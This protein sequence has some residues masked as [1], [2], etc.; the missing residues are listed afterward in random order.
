MMFAWCACAN[1]RSAVYAADCLGLAVRSTQLKKVCVIQTSGQ[2]LLD[3]V[4]AIFGFADEW[5]LGGFVGGGG[6]GGRF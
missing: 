2:R 3:K 5:L 4:D 1:L 6:G